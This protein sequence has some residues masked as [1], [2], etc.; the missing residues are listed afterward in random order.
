MQWFFDKTGFPLFYV[1]G[2]QVQLLP[3]TKV[4]FEKFL[5]ESKEFGDSWYANLLNI[6]PRVSYKTFTSENREGIFITGLLP[7]E[8]NFFIKWMGNGFRLANLREWRKIYH[9]LKKI[10]LK[11]ERLENL[12]FQVKSKPAKTI[13][14]RLLEQLNYEILYREA[15]R[16]LNWADITLMHYG[17]V[18]WVK[19][20]GSYVGVGAPRP[21]FYPN[22]WEPLKD[23]VKPLKENERL[24]YFGFR[25]I[26]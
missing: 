26:R 25:L 4:Q 21:S 6:N 14:E 22:L 5:V 18:E 20:E 8:I 12:L 16:E 17:L 23:M 3:I 10:P 1:S 24:F 2:I 15:R 19:E 11:R 13:I 7:S 9:E